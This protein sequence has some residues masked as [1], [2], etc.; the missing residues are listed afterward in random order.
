[1]AKTKKIVIEWMRRRKGREERERE[2]TR[3]SSHKVISN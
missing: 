2:A 3:N 1:M